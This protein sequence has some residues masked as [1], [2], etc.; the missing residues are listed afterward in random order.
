MQEQ[1]GTD[2]EVVIRVLQTAMAP[3][4]LLAALASLLN[5]LTTRLARVIDRSRELQR[6]FIVATSAEQDGLRQELRLI[7]RRKKLC[8][9]S[10]ML[11]VLGAIVICFIVALLFLM[12]LSS[13][14]MATLVIWMFALAMALVAASLAALLWETGLAAHEVGV[15]PELI[16]DDLTSSE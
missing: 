7:S 14:S 4:F 15:P 1:W 12:G 2:L 9:A 8:R 11:A 5:V 3:A 13:F 10:I 16:T 6:N